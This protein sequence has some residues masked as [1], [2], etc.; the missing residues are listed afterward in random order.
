MSVNQRSLQEVVLAY[1]ARPGARLR[2]R[3]D[4]SC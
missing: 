4:A 1:V 2:R 3:C